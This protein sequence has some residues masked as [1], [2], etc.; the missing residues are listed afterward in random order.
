MD[1]KS[2]KSVSPNKKFFKKMLAVVLS[3]MV[4]I[5]S[6]VV[7]MNSNNAAKDTIDVIRV[8]NPQGL[9]ADTAITEDD[10]EV[11]DVI[12]RE[13]DEN[14]YRGDEMEQIVGK[15]PAY[16]IRKEAILFKDQ[17]TDQKVLKNEWLYEM[18][19]GKEAVTI[20]YDYIEC[21]G[22]ILTPGDRIRV[23]A[24]YES[25][26]DETYSYSEP[27]QDAFSDP[28]A[29]PYASADPYGSS[30]STSSSAGEMKTE[31]V[32]DE[33]VV[34]DMLNSD[35]HSIYE[36]YK[37]VAKL[38]EDRKQ[39]VMKTDDFIKSILPKALVLEATPDRVNTYALMKGNS[40]ELV[41]TILSRSESNIILDDLST[42]QSEV[43]TWI[44]KNQ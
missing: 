8:K 39:A 15:F 25:D 32:F 24:V 14:M 3:V 27:M 44:E 21:G 22:D 30:Y 42:L 6:F 40:A 19:D 9:A 43:E 12:R 17:L 28:Y 41:I 23:R 35:S 31:I 7:I 11:Y 18:E 34:K 26:E 10:I 38:P 13:Y 36:I 33:I 4:F 20:P 29:D 37:E 5:V 16:F 1:A 2:V